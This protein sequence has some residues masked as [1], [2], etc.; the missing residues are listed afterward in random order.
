MVQYLDGLLDSLDR[1][2]ENLG[3]TG[4]FHVLGPKAIKEDN[5]VI[6]E[7]LKTLSKKFLQQPETTLLQEWSSCKQ[8]LHTGAFKVQ[9]NGGDQ[10]K[11]DG[12]TYSI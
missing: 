2:F 7:D 12:G 10:Q 8:H 11:D 6:T 5:A 4:A 9:I 3:I 1:R